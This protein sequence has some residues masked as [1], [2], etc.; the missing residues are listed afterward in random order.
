MD[1]IIL[2]AGSVSKVF[3]RRDISRGF[4]SRKVTAVDSVSFEIRKGSIFGLVGE[5]GSGKTTLARC[6]LHLDPPTEGTVTFDGRELR[7]LS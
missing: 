2:K 1:E 6:L 4:I 5:S 3:R 7:T